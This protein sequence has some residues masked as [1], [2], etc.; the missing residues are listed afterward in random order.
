MPIV[1]APVSTGI[2]GVV[3]MCVDRYIVYLN[4]PIDIIHYVIFELVQ[5]PLSGT[6]VNKCH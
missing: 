6:G 1:V 4:Y 2:I 5:V 3:P